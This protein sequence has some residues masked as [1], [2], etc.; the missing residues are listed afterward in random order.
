MFVSNCYKKWGT[1][2]AQDGQGSACFVPSREG[3]TQGDPP[4]HDDL[5]AGNSPPLI[6]LMKAQIPAPHQ[7]WY[8]DNAAIMASWG[9]IV[10]YFTALTNHGPRFRFYLEPEILIVLVRKG[11]E[12]ASA[13]SFWTCI[14]K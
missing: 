13:R 3:V 2:V 10:D 9:L 1:L 6:T 7:L 14:L 5:R 12:E 11:Q 8:A 4:L